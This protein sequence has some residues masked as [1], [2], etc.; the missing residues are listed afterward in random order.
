MA[1]SVIARQSGDDFQANVFWINACG[2]SNP[3]TGISSVAWEQNGTFGFDDVVVTYAPEK[4]ESDGRKYNTDFYQVKYHVDEAKGFTYEALMDPGF[5]GNKTESI[6][7]RLHKSYKHDREA[8][9]NNRY[10]IL[11]TWGYASN[12]PLR[13]LVLNSGYIRLDRLFSGG[14]R[15]ETGE[16]RE[17]WKKHLGIEDD[18]ELREVLESFRIDAGYYNER[19]VRLAYTS[20]LQLAGLKSPSHIQISDSY[21]KLIQ[22]LQ[23]RGHTTFTKDELWNI[24]TVE[25]LIELQEEVINE[26]KFKIGI[27]SFSKGAENLQHVVD[28]ISCFLHC[29]NERFLLDEYTDMNYLNEQINELAEFAKAKGEP[30]ELY[31][32]THIPIAFVFGRA[33]NYKQTAIDITVVQKTMNGSL[34]W[35]PEIEKVGSYPKPLWNLTATERNLTG[36]DLAI[37]VSISRNTQHEVDLYLDANSLEVKS[38]LHF[39][40]NTGVGQNSIID[41]NHAVAAMDDLVEQVRLYKKVN[42]IIGSIHL[43]FSGP[44]SMAF[45]LGQRSS[46]LKNINLYDYD[47]TDDRDGGYHHIVTIK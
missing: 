41:A 43:F 28:R 37:S 33:L 5:I 21:T 17:T 32:D 47:F 25:D 40:I 42:G 44:V 3:K 16:I 22:E 39:E 35:R 14:G 1:N 20:N 15:S 8:Y 6:L 29:F 13:K 31:F 36:S 45:F 2:L 11:N 19:S 7:Q 4:L 27:R 24:L 9:R 38:H 30:L 34:N 12:D 46:V 18:N 10:S 23:K 26:Q